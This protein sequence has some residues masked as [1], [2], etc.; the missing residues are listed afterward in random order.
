MSWLPQFFRRRTL[1]SNL[2][3][4][5]REHLSEATELLMRAENLS[6]KEAEHAARRAFG[7]ATLL[8]ERSREV[9]QWPTLESIRADIRYALRQLRKSPASSVTA[10]A[11]L[12]LGMGAT[13]AVFSLV[14]A[15]LLKPVPYPDPATLVIPWNI[16]PAGVN[17]GGFAEYPWGP[18]HFHAL[19]QQSKTFKYLGAFQGANFNLTESGDPAMLEGARVSWGFFPALGVSPRLGRIFTRE[20]DTPG[21]EQE[22][23]LGDS[24]WRSRFH[25]DPSIVNR[26]IRLN[27]A[28]YTIIGVMPRGFAFPRANEMPGDFDFPS[29][30][31]LWVPAAMP[32]VTPPFT[33]SELAVVGRLESGL[34]VAQA[35]AAMDLFATRMDVLYP[36][37]KGWSRS[38]VTPL[39]RQVAGDTRKPL[40]LIFSAVAVVL[41]IV[42]FNVA[43]LLI[44]RSITRRREFTLRAALGAGR[45]RVL[46]QLLTESLLLAVAGGLLGGVVAFSGVWLVRTFGPV[47]I[48]RLHEAGADLRVFA[49]A[50]GI[51][52]FTG[53][54][55]GLAP[56]IGATRVD[57]VSSL[58][59]GGQKSGS[60][61]GHLR[62]P[63]ALIVSQIALALVLVAA[64]G[65]LVR[66]FSRLLAADSGFR[67]E[68]V[69]TSQLS[70]PGT[71]YP[72]REHIARFYQQALPRLRSVAGVESAGIVEVV[73]MGG[74]TE[75]GV[76]H[77]V[78]RPVP[79]GNHYP[80]V[81][82]TIVSPGLFPTL[83]TPLLRGRDVLDS[84]LLDAP[85]LA[86]IN[87][88]MA[89][90][91]WPGEDPIGKQ[92]LIPSQKIPATIIGIVA[93]I[94]HSSLRESPEPEVFEP[95][96]QNVW[97]SMALMQIVLR[98]RAAPDSVIGGARAAIHSLDPS[99]PIAKVTTLT[100]L[101]GA[102]LAQDK[103]SILLLGFFGVFSLLLAAA[104]IY[105]VI[106]YSV[107]HRTRE[108]GIRI[109]LGAHRRNV[110]RMVLGH[111]LRL[112]AVGIALGLFAAWAAGH[113][114]T[115]FLYGVDAADPLTF[116]VV[117]LFLAAVAVLSTLFPAR[118]AAAI[119]PMQALRAE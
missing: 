42:C 8:E 3:E 64:A 94:K 35:Q 86:V 72:D 60:T 77:I 91:Y 90:Q 82:Y 41:L 81:N 56:A 83:G 75:A 9:W 73:P 24:L 112:A 5:V 45:A 44:T 105:G 63:S 62:L 38:R 58:K 36:V 89:R 27:G 15:I 21:R 25:A 92:I 74:A 39:Q 22:V 106:S 18:T 69:L 119:D 114:L 84:D 68:H 4:E 46:R 53:I 13:T 7:N 17:V 80:I 118:R 40:M 55:F 101:T 102:A 32:A 19:E 67:A 29:E 93:D 28:P 111:G 51:T 37:M 70:L 66:S 115:G 100:A 76:V 103:F 97:P 34:T 109:A 99:L 117:T 65:L 1:Y 33:P 11:L 85:A 57:L 23:V 113:L 52:L 88:A 59:E 96:T 107:G 79:S 116:A 12:G 48:P 71:Q 43:G 31:Q 95:Y 78:G 108:I 50:C 30:T 47:G 2:S 6:R 16:P 61:T 10:I 54:L 49:F 20:E 110:F 87:R 104:G 26:T 14:D 98:T